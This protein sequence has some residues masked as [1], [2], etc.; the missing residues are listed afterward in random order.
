MRFALSLFIVAVLLP[1]STLAQTLAAESL[2]ARRAAVPPKI[3]GVL[4]DELWASEP[5]PLGR[6]MSYNPLRGEPAQQ[7]TSVWVGY[8]NEAIYFAFK[9]FD[10]EP[11][12][13]RTTI[14]RRGRM[15]RVHS[16]LRATGDEQSE[17]NTGA[18]LPLLAARC[19]RALA[20]SRPPAQLS[21]D[22][23]LSASRA[24]R[25]AVRIGSR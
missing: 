17:V 21:A 7:P 8:D 15:S 3:D 18:G 6:W 19:A 4:D 5:L 14:S 25:F 1:A 23:G 24:Q 20:R 22:Q 2:R 10:A 9:C 11:D 12:K 13:I 16:R